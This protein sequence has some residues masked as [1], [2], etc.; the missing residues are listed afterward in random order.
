VYV[1][2]G[3]QQDG[4]A[5]AG[6]EEGRAEYRREYQ[7]DAQYQRPQEEVKWKSTTLDAS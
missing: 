1:V 6:V 3:E 5:C 7:R 4:K 2:K